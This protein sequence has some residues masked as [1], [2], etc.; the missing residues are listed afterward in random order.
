MKRILLLICTAAILLTGILLPAGVVA[1][2]D[3]PITMTITCDPMPEIEGD[4]TIPSLLFTIRNESENDYLLENA[5]LSGGFENREM[6]LDERI[7][8]PAGD[9]KEFE[10]TDV[11]V[12]SDQLDT[13]IFYTLSWEETETI[14]DEETGDA[15]F[16]THHRESIASL[17]IERFVVPELSVFALCEDEHVRADE[18]FTVDY[19]IKN[20]TDFDM[21]G[22]KLCD[23]EQSMQSIAL[24]S[25]ALMAGES[26]TVSVEYKMGTQ[27][28]RFKPRIEY[29]ARRREM[30]T[31]AENTLTVESVTVD[32]KISVQ[33]YPATAE[34]TD[35]VVT[36]KNAGNKTLTDIQIF[37]EIN[38]AID[39][40]FDLAAD[41]VKTIRCSVK[42]A[43]SSDRIRSVQFH[44][45]AVD[46]FGV[47]F[48][49]QD[50]ES[51][52]V[53]PFVQSD[54][55]HLT[56]TATVQS[57]FY[58]ENKK[59]CAPIQFHIRYSGG[60]KIRNAVL[61]ELTLF[62]KVV[63]YDELRNGDRYFTQTYQLDGI[64][65][66]RFRIDAV[67]PAGQTCSSE[68]IVVDV[69]GLRE[70]ADRKP[71]HIYVQTTNP[72]M[73]DLDAKYS[74]VL[75]TVLI[76]GLIVAAVCAIIC[77][78]LYAVET[79]IRKKLPA[80][81]EE[82][83]ER[84][85]RSTKRR[86]EKQLF[87]DSP[88]E[89]FGYTAPIKLR[90]YGELT[91]EEA[92]ARREAYERG[93]RESMRREGLAP[94]A[95]PKPQPKPQHGENEGTRVLPVVK[96]RP[97]EP[98]PQ[99]TTGRFEKPAPKPER[100]A[101]QT[102]RIERPAPKPEESDATRAVPVMKPQPA[103]VP[104]IP[105]VS[106]T[107][108]PKHE[109]GRIEKPVQKP[110]RPAQQTGR[111]ERPA[112]QTGRIER[113][114]PKPEESD[115]TRAV[116]VVKPQPAA[117]P[118][119]PVVSRTAE[120][121]PDVPLRRPAPEPVRP[122]P[123]PA[124]E[125]ERPQLRPTANWQID[126][127]TDTVGRP[128]PKQ[129]PVRTVWRDEPQPVPETEDPFVIRRR[130]TETAAADSLSASAPKGFRIPDPIPVKPQDGQEPCK[131]T[132]GD[133]D[134]GV[135][136]EGVSASSE[137][138]D[139][140]PDDLTQDGQEETAPAESENNPPDSLR[141]PPSLT[142]GGQ[143]ESVPVEPD[144]SPDDIPQDEQRESEPL[145][146]D[147]DPG[148]P[149]DGVN[150]SSEP[151]NNPPDDIPQDEQR[152]SEPLV[153]DADPGVPQDGVN[154]SSEPENNSPDDL[155]QDEQEESAPAEPNNSPDVLTQDGQEES[156]PVEPDNPP[157]DIPQ[158]EQRE[159][160]PLVGDA[161]PGVPHEGISASSES[162]NNPP[163]D[164]TRDEQEE[165][166]PVE[167]ENNPPDSLVQ[168]GQEP[169]KPTVGDAD[170][171][172]PQADPGVPQA[173]PGVP[174]DDISTPPEPEPLL[175]VGPRVLQEKPKLKKRPPIGHPIVRMNG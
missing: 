25:N 157:D 72:Y 109:T 163:D 16:V 127:M 131:P 1:D 77:I 136:H 142:H 86:T 143:E 165:S 83:L 153:G 140:S 33:P 175:P 50:P 36:V 123:K 52:Q 141:L 152:E 60:V 132:V 43:V 170:P 69:S 120:P 89:R 75:R 56:L 111:I 87:S 173:D 148:V 126:P 63:E 158:D 10:L 31:E 46:C 135:P 118:V 39:Q 129:P 155:T 93:L 54:D 62:G 102:G 80:E 32:L 53:L 7:T 18:T 21:T 28:M 4:G 96:P 99:N 47:Q 49:V 106:R 40:P 19:T 66:L 100:P 51:Y 71:D 26:V 133:A 8:V 150:A 151:E 65:E 124:A 137:P 103:A 116:P 95:P 121:I 108:E 128:A 164:V 97:A 41:Q 114:A 74:G 105:V 24:E 45:K 38:T 161:D 169:C 167:S 110:E 125:R 34:G 37:D 162:E 15:T 122:A 107:A 171:G 44:V 9:K 104:V 2:G 22:L 81:F 145:V 11:P 159:S 154:A 168:D 59:L 23:P 144:N 85:M 57:P 90:N 68:T 79:K 160:E 78:V 92:K 20:D 94:A 146:G 48:T 3:H 82:D 88:T 149:H 12:T 112:Q 42:P 17:L 61:T 139:N 156:V 98:G 147:A 91:E 172:V 138:E 13:E 5:K 6:I 35:F 58:D 117:V 115:A 67:D 101:Q 76:I 27:D 14:I 174:L 134:P 84:A 29:I 70:I 119:I 130:P 73:Q 166:A 64:R 55:V 30:T 113:P